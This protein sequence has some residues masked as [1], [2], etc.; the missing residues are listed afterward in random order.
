MQKRPINN[1]QKTVSFHTL[2]CRLN[3]S[4]TG[5]MAQ[6]F[7]KRGYEIKDFGEQTD[8][9]FINTCTVTDSADSSCRNQIRKAH[10]Y[11]PEGKI[12]VA[13]CYSQMEPETISK[14]KGV[15]LV[16]GTSEKYKVFDYLDEDD[17]NKIKIEKSNEFWGAATSLSDSHTRAFLKIQDGCNYV[18][19]FCII[20]FARGRS[21]TITIKDAVTKAHEVVDQGFK[22]IV[23]TG[24]NIGE[25]ENI[26]G[27]KL[28]DLFS[29]IE[30]IK[31]L[32][33]IRLSSVEPNTFTDDLIEVLK[34]SDKFLNHFHIPLQSGDDAILKDMRRKYDTSMYKELV[35][36]LSEEFP[37]SAFGADIIAG[38]PGESAEQ[39]EKT[40]NFASELPLTHFHVFP[41]SKRKGTSASKLDNHIPHHV[42]KE[43][44][45]SLIDL[46]REKLANFSKSQLHSK[47]KVLFEKRNKAGLFEGYTSN[48]LR[49]KLDS[50]LDLSNEIGEVY[51][52]SFQDGILEA[53]LIQ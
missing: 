14:M 30:K 52:E 25:Y 37:G 21:R 38:Y 12:V 42:K 36:R 19:S 53:K 11:S 24:V 39:F 46:G 41:Y 4:E 17:I 6:E 32:K 15:D 2:G 18:C 48:F 40:Y 33:R 9:T 26:S 5:S 51:L 47:N 27:E 44:V 8:V 49:V 35:H 50:D 23:L 31:G 28:S 13:G 10:K 20:P 3:F 22:E 7:E 45:H 43:R 29:E 16:L 1:K 34:K